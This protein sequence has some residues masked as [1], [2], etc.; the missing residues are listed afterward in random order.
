MSIGVFQDLVEIVNRAPVN[1]SVQFDG[2]SHTLTPGK[3]FIPRVTIPYAKNQNPFKGSADLDNPTASGL[4][5]LIGV[6]GTRDNCEPLTKEEWAAHT[7]SP[8][9]FNLEDILDLASRRLPPGT[10]LE[11]KNAR[12]Q[13]RFTV[14]LNPSTEFGG[15]D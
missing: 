5:F 1:L 8:S 15:G 11:V 4:D 14:A 9:R 12:K 10:R 2:Q 3:N 13:S 7:T 6:V